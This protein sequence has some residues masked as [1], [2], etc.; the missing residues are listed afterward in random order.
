MKSFLQKY[1]YVIL[2]IIFSIVSVGTISLLSKREKVERLK[3]YKSGLYSIGKVTDFR[4]ETRSHYYK[5]SFYFNNKLYKAS[6]YCGGSSS[7]LHIDQKY[8]IILNPEKPWSYNYLL[9]SY[10]VPDSIT[11]AP[12]EGWKELPI[13]VD[14]EEIRKFLEDY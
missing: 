11:E 13:P 2:A 1:K 8:F 12:P 7:S 6:C 4:K 9:Y 10:P 3:L 14:K 5:Y